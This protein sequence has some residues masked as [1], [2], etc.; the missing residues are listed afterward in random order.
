M[1]A[2]LRM[3]QPPM[4]PR[5]RYADNDFMQPTRPNNVFIVDDSAGIRVRLT[6]ML[7]AMGGMR[8]VGEAASAREAIAGIIRT[9]PDSVLLDLNLVG[10]TG[11]DVLRAVRPRLPDTVFVVLTNHSEPQYRKAC[12]EAG[13]AYFLDKSTELDRVREVLVEIASTSY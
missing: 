11:L 6:E 10:P 7:G 12:A 2:G 13:A 4:P 8:V 1:R 5:R 3:R 9:R